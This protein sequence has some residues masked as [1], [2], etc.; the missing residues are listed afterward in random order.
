MSKRSKRSKNT[1]N[2]TMIY[3]TENDEAETNQ[4]DF[5][6]DFNFSIIMFSLYPL[7]SDG[8]D[9]TMPIEHGMALLDIACDMKDINKQIAIVAI[10]ATTAYMLNIDELISEAFQLVSN[11]N[12]M[13]DDFYENV[14]F[15]RDDLASYSESID[16]IL[17]ILEI[18]NSAK[19]RAMGEIF[20]MALNTVMS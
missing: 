19:E 10:V 20:N 13:V 4:E 5:A 15:S 17:E 6:M 9:N 2:N 1:K 3:L 14:R 12:K 18:D 11:N 16:L 7:L 8:K